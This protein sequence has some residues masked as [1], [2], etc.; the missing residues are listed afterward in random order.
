MV[1]EAATQESIISLLARQDE[2][3]TAQNGVRTKAKDTSTGWATKSN[4]VA[5]KT[6]GFAAE[7]NDIMRKVANGAAS[8]SKESTN[9]KRQL[10]LFS[11]KSDSSLSAYLASFARYLDDQNDRGNFLKDLS[12]T[13]GQRRNHFAHRHTVVSGSLEE[14]KTKISSCTSISGRATKT[15]DPTVGFVF[16]GQGAQYAQM[17][18]DLHHIRPFSAALNRAD[19]IIR[20][21][22]ASWSLIGT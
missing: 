6:N 7:T 13:L 14:L 22:G 3:F 4:D 16:T 17:V 19:E 2:S 12:F 20:K 18:V 15:R 8:E 10:F 21:F 1:L 9:A 5:A 11:A